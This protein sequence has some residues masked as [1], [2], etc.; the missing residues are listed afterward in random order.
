MFYLFLL[1]FFVIYIVAPIPIQ[2]FI[3][4]VDM[5][6]PDPIPAIDE[7]LMVAVVG[8]RIRKAIMIGDFVVKH[9]FLTFLIGMVLAF[10]LYTVICEISI[11][12]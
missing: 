6:I 11:I 8:N 3:L 12:L 2:I 1:G 10:L 9:K 5:F 7:I 4:I